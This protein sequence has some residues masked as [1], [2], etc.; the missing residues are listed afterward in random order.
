MLARL[1]A[2]A[3]AMRAA[4]KSYLT[5]PKGERDESKGRVVGAAAEVLDAEMEAAKAHLAG[6]A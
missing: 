5:A 3:D 1:L 2:A 4:Q 6:S